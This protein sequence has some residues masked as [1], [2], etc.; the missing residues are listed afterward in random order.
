LRQVIGI[1][2][3]AHRREVAERTGAREKDLCFNAQNA[4]PRGGQGC[5]KSA[6]HGHVM[7]RFQRPTAGSP[8][9]TKID[10]ENGIGLI[11][12]ESGEECTR[13][14]PERREN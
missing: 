14:K 5:K 2:Q 3:L 7:G 13:R 12:D 6:S 1:T 8:S 11:G 9:G 4:S 10:E